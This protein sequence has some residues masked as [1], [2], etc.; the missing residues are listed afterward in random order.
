MA[1]TYRATNGGPLNIA[2]H[3]GNVSEIA[4]ANTTAAAALSTAASAQ[5]AAAAAQT[6]ATN[7]STAAASKVPLTRT[8]NG[9]PLSADISLNKTHIGLPNVENVSI[10]A[11]IAALSQVSS[12]IKTQA[13][14]VPVDTAQASLLAKYDYV[15]F[16]HYPLFGDYSPVSAQI[17]AIKAINPNTQCGLYSIAYET[18]TTQAKAVASITR[19]GSTITVNT[20]DQFGSPTTP[21]ATVGEHNLIQNCPVTE[22]NGLWTVTS[23]GSTSFQATVTG[24]AASAANDTSG[25]ALTCNEYTVVK[26]YLQDMGYQP[27]WWVRKQGRSGRYCAWTSNF[28]AYDI[29][30]TSYTDANSNGERA[31]QWLAKWFWTNLYSQVP[32]I[33]FAFMDNYL[34]PRGDYINDAQTFSGMAGTTVRNKRDVRM[35]GG[36]NWQNFTDADVISAHRLGYA[37]YG[38]S[39]VQRSVGAAGRSK[40]LWR[41]GNHDCADG[42]LPGEFRSTVEAILLES[43]VNLSASTLSDW[44]DYG[45]ISTLAVLHE[46]KHRLL[47]DP[48]IVVLECL[49][50]AKNNYE[51]A[52]FAIAMSALVDHCVVQVKADDDTVTYPGGVENRV[53]TRYDEMEA[54]SAGNWGYWI[55]GPQSAPYSGTLYKRAGTNVLV[56]LNVGASPQSIDLTGQ[57]WSRINGTLDTTVNNGA[58]VTGSFSVPAK[59]ARVLVK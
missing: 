33:D 58:A 46:S 7:A 53:P 49:M 6:S 8:V 28:G 1:L 23:V 27:T 34:N 47:P 4:N 45:F 29:N 48:G 43:F 2:Q 12:R 20:A 36:T 15:T 11:S 13:W 16:A 17:S 30:L 56:L 57:G 24:A 44:I 31:P 25:E 54:R 26:A 9:L 21:P 41:M 3:D 40:R 39:L 35:L 22:Y 14:Y 18:L 19:S 59:S 38:E 37:A 51:G 5:T 32:K 55:D 50:S 10:S 52:R 42:V